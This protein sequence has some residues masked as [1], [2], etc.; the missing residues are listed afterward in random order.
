MGQKEIVKGFVL[1][2]TFIEAS[3]WTWIQVFCS[4]ISFFFVY[5]FIFPPFQTA[6]GTEWWNWNFSFH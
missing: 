2:K 5:S 3:S 4:K 1:I 6:T